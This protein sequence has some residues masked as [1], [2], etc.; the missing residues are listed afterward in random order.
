MTMHFQN[1]ILKAIFQNQT[2]ERISSK[3]EDALKFLAEPKNAAVVTLSVAGAYLVCRCLFTREKTIPEFPGGSLFS[4]HRELLEKCS[5]EGEFALKVNPFKYPL[6]YFRVACLKVLLICD[7]KS[8]KEIYMT[9]GMASSGRVKGYVL[10]M[11]SH[12]KHAIAFTKGDPWKTNRQIFLKHIRK[13]GREKQFELILEE[14]G[15]LLGEIEKSQKQLEPTRLLAKVFCNTICTFIFGSRIDYSD[16]EI[17][18]I[19]GC[20]DMFNVQN[21][22][23]PEF[24]WPLMAMFPIFPSMRKRRDGIQK[25]KK[26]LATRIEPLLNSGPRNPPETLVEA[27]A[28]DIIEKGSGQLN[29][30]ALV[31]II[32]ELFFAGTETSST[33]ILWFLAFMAT[34]PDIQE[35]LFQEVQTV[36]GDGKL[37]LS[38]LKEIDYLQAV[39]FEVQRVGCVVHTAPPHVMLETIQLSSGEKIQKGQIIFGSV[40]WVMR[41]EDFWKYPNEFNPENFLDENGKFVTSEAFIPYG[42]GPRVCLGQ[43]LADMELKITICEL[44][45]KFKISCEEK[46]DLTKQCQKATCSPHPYKYTFTTR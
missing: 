6:G 14:I 24:L 46:I 22:L 44:V 4:G 32:H 17:E 13:W 45:R 7:L 40:H 42:L 1:Y 15:F 10:H 27:Y 33:T 3:I 28:L 38:H 5:N 31:A 19:L 21:P 29:N 11:D 18:I 41:H 35:K 9:H 30:D 12:F 43:S 39:Q 26:Y 25:V 37:N 2:S 34:Y 16:P 8:W 23:L 36:I 20:I